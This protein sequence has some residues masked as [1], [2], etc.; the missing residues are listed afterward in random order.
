MV[1]ATLRFNKAT[2][3]ELFDLKV[4]ASWDELNQRQLIY[5]GRYWESW[6]Q[7]AEM[8]ESLFKA[9]CML[10]IELS[11]IENRVQKK[12]LCTALA[13]VN[14]NTNVNVISWT[15]FIFKRQTLT[16]NIL[17]K[18]KI[19]WFKWF[20][21]PQDKLSDIDI[22]EFSFAYSAYSSYMNTG[23][24]AHLDNLVAVLYRPSS[25]KYHITGDIRV[26]FNYKMIRIYAKRIKHLDNSYKQAVLLYFI[27]CLEFFKKKYGSVFRRASNQ[28]QVSGSF[29]DAAIDISGGKF[30]PFEETKRT[31]VHVFLKE[32]NKIVEHHSKK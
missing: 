5:I 15:D 11:G 23:V 17:P 3:A 10:F 19:G 18:I 13:F 4:P 25:N 21:G 7:L 2:G 1:E 6:K 31:N 9:R 30:G 12:R 28:T 16:K 8:G 20:F 26:P 24:E 27:G 22:E 29:I 14:E 32:L